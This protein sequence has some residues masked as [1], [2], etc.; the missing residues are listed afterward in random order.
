MDVCSSYNIS[1]TN[2][3]EY[4][5]SGRFQVKH[6][7][8]KTG[9]LK[10][11]NINELQGILQ[12]IGWENLNTSYGQNAEGAGR[13]ELYYNTQDIQKKITYYRLEPQEIRRLENY[14][15]ILINHDEF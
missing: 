8:E 1:I 14:L 4:N 11:S 7:G 6:L 3:G 10:K 12:S 9:K 5:Y 13:K 15:D 2:T